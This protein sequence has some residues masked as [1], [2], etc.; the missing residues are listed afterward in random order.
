MIRRI[1]HIIHSINPSHGGTTEAVR[2]LTGNQ[3]GVEQ[4]VISSDDPKDCWGRD[5]DAKTVL[6]GPAHTKFG[7]NPRLKECLRFEFRDVRAVVIHGLWQYHTLASASVARKTQIPYYVFPHGMLDPWA[8]QQSSLRKKIAWTAFNRQVMQN[9]SGICY[10]THEE[11]TLAQPF[12]QSAPENDLL[13]PLGVEAPPCDLAQLK[14]EFC[15]EHPEL[16]GKR[17]FLFLGRLHHKKG[18][19]ILIEAFSNWRHSSRE[20]NVHLRMT[21]P[22]DN[23]DYHASLT[24]ICERLGLKPGVDVSFPGMANGRAKWQELAAAE[25]LILPSHQENFGLVVGEA[26]ACGLPVM[27][28][29]KVNTSTIV[30][31]HGAGL[32]ES[33]TLAGTEQLLQRWEATSVEERTQMS[34]HA[35]MLYYS[36]FSADKSRS[37][38]IKAILGRTACPP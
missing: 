31:A 4:V 21:G 6:T 17:I 7:W 38:F 28:S 20:K 27:L 13:I 37:T 16:A 23:P 2:L 25:V 12:V 9:A 26:L 1:V 3:E 24:M 33:D 19:D 8:L 35:K 30:A 11:R 29:D 22:I 15:E 34:Q 32:V 14:Q 36:S 5:W 18:C 10:T